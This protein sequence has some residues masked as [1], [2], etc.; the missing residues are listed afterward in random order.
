LLRLKAW[1]APETVFLLFFAFLSNLG[2]ILCIFRVLIFK[3]HIFYLIWSIIQENKK[4]I[5][6]MKKRFLD[7]SL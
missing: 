2:P 1:P 6:K 3:N 5:K 4:N 7:L